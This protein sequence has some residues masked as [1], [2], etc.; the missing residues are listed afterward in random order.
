MTTNFRKKLSLTGVSK[1]FD[2]TGDRIKPYVRLKQKA[3]YLDATA[4][5]FRYAFEGCFTKIVTTIEDNQDLVSKLAIGVIVAVVS[6]DIKI[7]HLI[8]NV[9]FN[10]KLRNLFL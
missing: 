6:G 9:V 10:S 2:S 4:C 1:S 3:E 8:S 7:T 5:L